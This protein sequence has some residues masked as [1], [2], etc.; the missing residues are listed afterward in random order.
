MIP[1]P[2]CMGLIKLG[3]SV[4]DVQSESPDTI[5][6]MGI[7]VFIVPASKIQDDGNDRKI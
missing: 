7:Q 3:N 5:T 6:I 4:S 2:Q 1:P